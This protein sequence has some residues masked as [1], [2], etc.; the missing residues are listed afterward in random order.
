MSTGL[1]SGS[2][3][4]KEVSHLAEPITGMV[5]SISSHS[6][7]NVYKYPTNMTVDFYVNFLNN[8]ISKFHL[9]KGIHSEILYSID[10]H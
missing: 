8:G 9:N 1:P 4:L 10:D 2:M 5:S 7:I 3:Y 6:L